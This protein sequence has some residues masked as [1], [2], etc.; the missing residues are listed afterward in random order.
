[1]RIEKN[2]FP[3]LNFPGPVNNKLIKTQIAKIW[4]KIFEIFPDG[5]VTVITA[6]INIKIRGK[7]VYLI[8]QPIRTKKP[9]VNSEINK[10]QAKKRGS[11]KPMFDNNDVVFSGFINFINP[12]YRKIIEIKILNINGEYSLYFSIIKLK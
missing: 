11:G 12:E 8:F 7:T 4:N 3:R 1:M 6:I 10:I 9:N 5:I 2:Y